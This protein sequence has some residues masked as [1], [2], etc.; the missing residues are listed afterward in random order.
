MTGMRLTFQTPQR[1]PYS[2]SGP[3]GPHKG[4]R[5][6]LGTQAIESQRAQ[7]V[8]VCKG[9]S[10]RARVPW[11]R[12]PSTSAWLLVCPNSESLRT[13]SFGGA[14]SHPVGPFS[15]GTP[16]TSQPSCSFKPPHPC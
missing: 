15:H 7:G 14:P 10:S 8:C 6:V 9:I 13:W 11:N 1:A 3:C 5:S 16:L 12:V 2:V 4:A